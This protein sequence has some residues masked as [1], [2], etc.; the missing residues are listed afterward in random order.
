MLLFTCLKQKIKERSSRFEFAKAY[1][2]EKR[3]DGILGKAEISREDIVLLDPISAKI[4]SE[5]TKCALSC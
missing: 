1:I 5:C 3:S 4:E 2:D